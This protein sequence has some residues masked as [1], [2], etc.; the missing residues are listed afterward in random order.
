M[1]WRRTVHSYITTSWCLY[2]NL[3]MTGHKS[4]HV[5]LGTHLLLHSPC[6]HVTTQDNIRDGSVGI[7]TGYWLDGPRIES[8]WGRDIPHTSSRA[9]ELTQPPI[10]WVPG[11]SREKSGRNVGFNHPPPPNAEV[12]ER[13]ELLLFSHSGSIWPVTGRPLPF[14]NTKQ[15][16]YRCVGKKTLSSAIRRRAVCRIHLE[17]IVKTEASQSSL[18]DLDCI[19]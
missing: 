5:L 18:V 17:T 13:V 8:R 7:V 19:T 16:N 1:F 12:K 3:K 10:Q 6:V 14:F 9:L 2:S 15:Q 4:K 11:L